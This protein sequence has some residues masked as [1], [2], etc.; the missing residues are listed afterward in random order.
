MDR[1]GKEGTEV[2]VVRQADQLRDGF[3][4]HAVARQGLDIAAPALP[5][6]F[7]RGL[8]KP[9]LEIELEPAGGDVQGLR[10]FGY[11]IVTLPRQRRPVGNEI[12]LALHP[13]TSAVSVSRE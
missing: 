3:A 11:S 7:A 8:V 9:L 12:Q 5:K 2:G 10:H 6:E 13:I 4:R 1:H